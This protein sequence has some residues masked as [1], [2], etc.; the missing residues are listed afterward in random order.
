MC[1]SSDSSTFSD[2]IVLEYT[3]ASRPVARQRPRSETTAVARQRSAK[4]Q[5]NSNGFM[6]GPCRDVIMRTSRVS[7]V[8]GSE[9]LVGT[10]VT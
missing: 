6:C 7:A 4:Q 3:V 8:Q 10:L 2:A 9:E 5:L 1:T